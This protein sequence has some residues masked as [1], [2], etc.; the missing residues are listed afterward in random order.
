[1]DVSDVKVTDED[2]FLSRSMVKAKNIMKERI[3]INRVVERDH[4]FS[5]C[6]QTLRTAT[7]RDS[8]LRSVQ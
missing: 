1:M 6:I 3:W 8:L 2:G 4:V 7:L 5:I